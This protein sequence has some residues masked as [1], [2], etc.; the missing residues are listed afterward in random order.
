MSQLTT[1]TSAIPQVYRSI[2]IVAFHSVSSAE[3]RSIPIHRSM[4]CQ[5]QFAC[6]PL[7]V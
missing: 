3:E 2:S 5:V 1:P 4:G 7:A 6:H